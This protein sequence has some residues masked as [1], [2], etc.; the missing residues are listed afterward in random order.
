MK[1]QTKTK[2]GTK[3]AKKPKLNPDKAA[4]QMCR[5]HLKFF[6]REFWEEVSGDE[7]DWNWHLDVLC[8]EIQAVYERVFLRLPKLYDLIINIPPGTTK[9]T[10]ASVMAP[11]WS[12]T[13]DAS[14]RHITAS[15]S[16]GL[17]TELSVK[18]R[19]IIRSDKF[20]KYFPEI[21]IKPDEDNKTNYKTTKK[22]QRYATSVGGTVT[23]IHGH[24]LTADD[25]INPKQAVSADLLATANTWMGSTFSSR[26]VNK[27]LTPTILIMQR[28]AADDPTGYL[29]E[30]AKHNPKKKIRLVVL[31]ATDSKYVHPVEYRKFYINGYLD[32]KRIGP[33]AIEEAKIDLGPAAYAAQFEQTPVPP[34]GL[35]WKDKWFIP[36]PD[37]RFPARK[38][39]S[40]YGTDW[41]LAYTDK[42]E[43]SACAYITSGV[44]DNKI[45]I[46][47][48]G[49]EWKQ[50]PQLI[51]WIKGKEAPHFI[52]AKATGKS[53]KQSLTAAGIAAIEVQVPGGSDK[54]ARANMATAMA[55]AGLVYVRASIL[56]RLLNDS[57]QGILYFPK[58]KY[59]DLADA[60]AQCITRHSKKGKVTV[61]TTD[62]IGYDDDDDDY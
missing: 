61:T 47:D 8:D 46:D 19:D 24:I 56:E 21:F 57:K 7:L 2:Q 6:V 5:R 53:A 49:W 3:P 38:F 26:K 36:V 29:L 30:K 45:F 4:S 10:I 14:L 51:S 27:M 13:R 20:K 59:A 32:P 42:E 55:A 44:L 34:G 54:I 60:L 25:L 18:S 50:Y 12:W 35:I 40:A 16:D 48:V 22:G 37:E 52:E 31:P 43:N 58:G 23:G 17:S 9:S 41:D 62:D 39:L 33:D 11:A 1:T 28:I 15:Y